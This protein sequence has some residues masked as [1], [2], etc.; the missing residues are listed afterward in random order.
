[1]KQ[2]M[3]GYTIPCVKKSE[4]MREMAETTFFVKEAISAGP[5]QTLEAMLTEMD[6]IERALIDVEDGEVKIQFDETKVSEERIAITLQQHGFH[7][8]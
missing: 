3:A 6:G 7:I 1:M 2:E 8:S 4:R 5:V